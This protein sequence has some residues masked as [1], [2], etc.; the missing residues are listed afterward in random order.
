MIIE[1][2]ESSSGVLKHISTPQVWNEEPTF[3]FTNT[4]EG[5]QSPDR[6]RR[7]QSHCDLLLVLRA[8]QRPLKEDQLHTES[9]LLSILRGRLFTEGDSHVKQ[10]II[11][12]LAVLSQRV[13]TNAGPIFSDLIA[14]FDTPK[15]SGSLRS[16]LLSA[17][18]DACTCKAP[19]LPLLDRIE[20]LSLQ[21]LQH[22]KALV[23]QRALE[24]LSRVSRSQDLQ[25]VIARV[26]ES[27]PDPR[28]RSAGFQALLLLHQR[29]VSL[30]IELYR[31][32]VAGMG[33]DYEEVRC[34]ALELV[35][36]LCN[37]YPQHV[38]ATKGGE[39]TRLVDDGKRSLFA[40]DGINSG[41]G[42]IRICNMVNDISMVVRVKAARLLGGLRNV[43]TQY[44]LQGFSKELFG[45]SDKVKLSRSKGN[46]VSASGDFDLTQASSLGL[47]FILWLTLFLLVWRCERS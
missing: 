45:R 34:F 32:A 21:E 44:L 3:N 5:L 22:S 25:L 16:A 46:D 31:R 35:W 47:T 6:A 17:L 38:F 2:I 12:C 39:Q 41:I 36:V 15:L 40:M 28:M 24:L 13:S 37:L 8:P 1:E 19:P 42:F 18:R 33:D 7:I 9:G 11:E 27:D 43:S 10:K 30:D 14:Q 23:R 29:Q 20:A 4:L 26:C